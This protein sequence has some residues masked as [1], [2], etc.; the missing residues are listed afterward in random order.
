MLNREFR[1][2]SLLG[3]RRYTVKTLKCSLLTFIFLLIRIALT[4]LPVEMVTNN[5][6]S[7]DHCKNIYILK[8]CVLSRK[9]LIWK[10]VLVKILVPDPHQNNADP[11]HWFLIKSVDTY[12]DCGSSSIDPVLRIR[13]RDPVL[14]GPCSETRE[15][16]FPVQTHI[17]ESLLAIF[18]VKNNNF[19]CQL[20]QIFVFSLYCT[21]QKNK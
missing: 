1:L 15:Q 10:K 16:Y 13:V 2:H 21:C 12:V 5:P 20:I 11:I 14:F 9:I 6:I 4:K 8:D 18:W 3:K 7:K 17:F 19:L